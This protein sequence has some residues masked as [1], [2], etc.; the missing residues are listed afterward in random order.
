MRRAARRISTRTRELIVEP[1]RSHGRPLGRDALLA[2]RRSSAARAPTW[3]STAEWA[4][5]SSRSSTAPV[6]AADP[7]P[8]AA[9]PRSATWSD[10]TARAATCSS[11]RVDAGHAQVGDHARSMP[12][13]GAY[14]YS[15]PEQLQRCAQA[16]RGPRQRGRGATRRAPRDAQRADE[17]RL[18]AARRRGGAA[19]G[20]PRKK[21]WPS[22]AE[23]AQRVELLGGLDALGDRPRARACA[24]GRRS[25]ARTS[26]R[27]GRA[28][29]PVDER[30]GDLERCRAA[31]SAGS[32]ATSSRCRS[33]RARA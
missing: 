6:H 30:L 22:P 1:G 15:L 10:T 11:S 20:R 13:T 27:G 29:Q 32:S 17:P 5:T 3:R 2:S 25:C 18:L 23:L 9:R 8:R 26:S 33:R 28:T 16:A 24:R 12:A 4:T 19:D 31:A 7:R 21:P 14:C